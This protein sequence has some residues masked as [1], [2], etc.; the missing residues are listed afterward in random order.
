ML[1]SATD[2]LFPATREYYGVRSTKPQT[3]QTPLPAWLLLFRQLSTV[4]NS[5][6][7]CKLH[8]LIGT[9]YSTMLLLESNK[10]SFVGHVVKPY[11]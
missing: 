3:N 2:A 1:G 7:L 11:L 6:F 9:T 10:R 8:P 5:H 4:S